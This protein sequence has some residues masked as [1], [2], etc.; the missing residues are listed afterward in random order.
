MI[1]RPRPDAVPPREVTPEPAPN[2]PQLTYSGNAPPP[3]GWRSVGMRVVQWLKPIAWPRRATIPEQWQAFRDKSGTP[4]GAEPAILAAAHDPFRNW[5]RNVSNSWR[6][7]C[8]LSFA[9]MRK[10]A[11]MEPNVVTALLQRA[12]AVSVRMRE[13]GEQFSPRDMLSLERSEAY[14]R[15]ML[16]GLADQDMLVRAYRYAM[17]DAVEGLGRNEDD[18]QDDQDEAGVA[19]HVR[20]GIYL[21][22][23]RIAL[24]GERADLAG[25]ALKRCDGTSS[26]EHRRMRE[27]LHH[28]VLAAWHPESPGRA[29]TEV[30][31]LFDAFRPPK[32]RIDTRQFWGAPVVVTFEL[33]VIHTRL[34]GSYARPVD[35]GAVF[36]KASA[37]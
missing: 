10:Y 11:G 16:T 25:E 21:E 17:R 19:D 4:D 29:L 1:D 36:R 27:T 32:P 34:E 24:V 15:W 6:I 8:D 12:L 23:A 13:E 20:D 18:A 9:L 31:K 26:R 7:E 37:P 28:A 33:G 5:N 3:R 35:L 14:A 22:A 30:G 2:W